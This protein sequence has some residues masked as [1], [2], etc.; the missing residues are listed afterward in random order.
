M[1]IK[2]YCGRMGGGKTYEVVSSVIVPA[3]GRGRRVV[4][5]IAGLNY[6]AICDY[7]TAQ[8]VDDDK[9][10][11]LVCVSHADVET[12]DFWLTETKMNENKKATIQPGD[13]IALD[14]IWRFWEGFASRK[15]PDDVMNFVRMHRHF[16]HEG[17]GLSCDLAI[18]TQ[19]VMDIARRVRA[20]VSETYVMTK[21]LMIGR[22]N[23]YRVAVFTGYKT[24]AKPLNDFFRTYNKKIFPLYSSHSQKKEGGADA[25]EENIDSRGNLFGRKMFKYVIPISIPIFLY[26]IYAVYGFFHPE[27]KKTDDKKIVSSSPA[28]VAPGANGAGPIVAGSPGQMAV[29]G[30]TS[31]P[32]VSPSSDWRIV[33]VYGPSTFFRVVLSDGQK[34]RYLINPRGF[35]LLGM[36]SRVDL[37][38]GGFATNYSG[39]PLSSVMRGGPL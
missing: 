35:S 20:V 14:E 26:T 36:N 10:G 11:E 31:S 23:Q 33:G 18:I 17:S 34:T 8:G 7:L 9:F 28:G 39:P 38:E 3:I 16:V 22:P 21:L 2:A 4:T 37:P 13:L 32:S 6:D 15:M 12:A 19:D 5:N 29:P 1:A 24:S 30:G 27:P 25:V